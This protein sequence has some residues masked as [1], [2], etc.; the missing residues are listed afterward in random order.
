MN[1]ALCTLYT[2]GN[3]ILIELWNI[4]N[5]R[6]KSNKLYTITLN[7]WGMNGFLKKQKTLTHLKDQ[8]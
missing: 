7:V 2:T 5:R 6:G 4:L 3:G 8:I 1:T